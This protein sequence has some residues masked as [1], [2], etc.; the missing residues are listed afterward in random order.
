MCNEYRMTRGDLYKHECMGRDNK[1]ARQGYY[2][3]AKTED[4]ARDKMKGYFPDET[5]FT[6]DFTQNLW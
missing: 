1:A 2:I 5:D 3:R 6:C 4:E